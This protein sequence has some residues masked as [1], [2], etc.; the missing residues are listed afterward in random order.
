MAA[1]DVVGGFVEA[2]FVGANVADRI[3]IMARESL[4]VDPLCNRT[5]VFRPERYLR[6]DREDDLA[7]LAHSDFELVGA[8]SKTL[9]KLRGFLRWGARNVGPVPVIPGGD[10]HQRNNG[11]REYAGHNAG[12]SVKAGAAQLHP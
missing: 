11:R 10:C 4:D 8:D 3:A 2:A 7:R 12:Q 5:V 9:G 1:V 6:M